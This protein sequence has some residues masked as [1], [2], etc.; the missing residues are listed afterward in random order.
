MHRS[1]VV[2]LAVVAAIFAASAIGA[3]IAAQP[4]RNA[5]VAPVEDVQIIPVQA[6]THVC[7]ITMTRTRTDGAPM[8]DR[9]CITGSTREQCN[10]SPGGLC[11]SSRAIPGI[12]QT[13]AWVDARVCG[14]AR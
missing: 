3:S 10:S 2:G 14:G 7:V 6:N 4:E 9:M 12:T 13:C 5:R 11:D 1:S 8:V